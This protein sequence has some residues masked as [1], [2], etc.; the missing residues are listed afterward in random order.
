MRLPVSLFANLFAMWSRAR[1]RAKPD[2]PEPIV[3]CRR[4]VWSAH[5]QTGQILR[6]ER[7]VLW[8]TQSGDARDII[9]R[10]GQDWKASRRGLVVAQAMQDSRLLCPAEAGSPTMPAST[11]RHEFAWWL[12]Q[13]TSTRKPPG[14]LK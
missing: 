5:L 11:C 1:P 10:A 2:A 7:G 14:A 3:L 6:C 8:L 12:Q 4:A 9:L 13:S